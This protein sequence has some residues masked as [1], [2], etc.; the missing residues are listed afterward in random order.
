MEKCEVCNKKISNEDIYWQRIKVIG[1]KV[2]HIYCNE[3]VSK[4]K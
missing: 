3:N 1:K 2:Y 4:P